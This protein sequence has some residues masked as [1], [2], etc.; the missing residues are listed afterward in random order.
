MLLA[1]GADVRYQI[2]EGHD[3]GFFPLYAAS[4]QGHEE[5]IE[6]L[7]AGGAD[8]N[9]VGGK[10]S[11]SSLYIAAQYD[12]PSAIAALV[13]AG[14]NVNLANSGGFTPLACAAFHGRREALVALLVARAAVNIADNEG[15]SPLYNAAQNGHVEILKLLIKAKGD[16]NQCDKVVGASPLMA[17][18][19]L[20]FVEAV[21]LLLLN[22]A[23]V[24]HMSNGGR[25]ALDQAIGCKHPSVEAVLRAH[26]AKLEAAGR[27]GEGERERAAEGK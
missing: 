1:L 16:V 27:E 14:A 15:A 12:Q 2:E 7:V 17:A 3:K 11:V 9:Q 4:E 25:T 23:D 26:I 19:R 18:S 6:A 8:L 10:Y 5:V 20:G 24:H 21:E 22:G 13:R